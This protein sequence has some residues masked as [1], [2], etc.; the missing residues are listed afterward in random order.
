MN[1]YRWDSRRNNKGLHPLFKF[2]IT[3][4]LEAQGGAPSPYDGDSTAEFPALQ[5]REPIS[6]SR[7]TKESS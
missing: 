3:F 7:A 5:S 4:E 1:S 6:A 2:D